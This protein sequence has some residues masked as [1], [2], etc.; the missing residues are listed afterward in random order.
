MATE[1][2]KASGSSMMEQLAEMQMSSS[3]SSSSSFSMSSIKLCKRK[4]LAIVESFSQVQKS[5]QIPEGQSM[6]DFEERPHPIRDKESLKVKVTGRPMPSV[7][8]ER[9]SGKPLSKGTKTF[10]DDINKHHVLKG[11]ELLRSQYSLGKCEQKMGTKCMLCI[12]IVGLDD[13]STY[14]LTV[15]EKSLSAKLTLMHVTERQ[16]AVFEVFPSKRTDAPLVW[17]VKGKEV[18]RGEK[19][20]MPVSEDGLTYTLKIKDVRASHTGDY[21]MSIRDLTASAPLFIERSPLK[22]A[23]HLKNVC[24]KEK[25]KARLQC[26]MSSKDHRR[27]VAP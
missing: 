26:E 10:Y 2:L 3:S 13:M 7:I 20:D 21:T 16:T 9:V 1:V 19:F 6:P 23:S 22:Y 12:S 24:V 11:T 18:K 27:L 15:G 17:K 4:V 5:L 25:G 14:T 8:W